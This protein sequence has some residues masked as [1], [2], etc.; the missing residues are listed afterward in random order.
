MSTE[1]LESEL[2][3]HEF[4]YYNDKEI[5]IQIEQK[6][7]KVF[8]FNLIFSGLCSIILPIYNVFIIYQNFFVTDNSSHIYIQ[9]V[10]YFEFIAINIILLFGII[11]AAN[12]C[13]I[14]TGHRLFYFNQLLSS[15]HFNLFSLVRYLSINGIVS[16]FSTAHRRGERQS[17][18][19]IKLHHQE[20]NNTIPFKFL[21]LLSVA[22]YMFL[23]IILLLFI[24]FSVLSKLTSVTFIG[25]LDI[26][27][28]SYTQ[29][30]LFIGI[31]NNLASL[32]HD[33]EVTL[34]F[35]WKIINEEWNA[36][37]GEWKREKLCSFR[38]CRIYEMMYD[39]NRWKTILWI[40]TMTGRELHDVVRR[41]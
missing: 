6:Y 29:I 24:T 3:F 35:M 18:Y 16:L 27:L 38:M 39:I 22:G 41:P 15:L 12:C 7:S 4:K 10:T 32:S 34:N 25:D 28:W 8:D 31:V 37:K 23:C 19:L 1:N 9:G 14:S 5:C 26:N 40:T 17:E 20:K 11:R 13:S 2:N 21:K 36:E 30:S 33:D